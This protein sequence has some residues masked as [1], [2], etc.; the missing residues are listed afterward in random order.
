MRQC[1]VFLIP[2]FFYFH[3]NA[4]QDRGCFRIMFWN[5]ENFYDTRKD[6][7]TNDEEFLPTGTRFWTPKRYHMKLLHAFKVFTAIGGWEPPDIIGLCE[8]ENRKV[9]TDLIYDTP[10]CK[11]EYGIVH[12]DSPDKRGIDVGMLYRKDTFRPLLSQWIR[13][14]FPDQPY[15]TTRDIM[16]VKGIARGKS[17]D[18]D[19]LRKV[20]DSI[21]VKSI[22][23]T[24]D[25]P[26][27]KYYMDT[28]HVFINHWPSRS[29]GQAR[30]D[31]KRLAAA[32]ILRA[33][34]D[35]LL[36]HEPG[37]KI[38]ITGDFN[39][40]PSDYS[41]T[42]G[43]G[44]CSTSHSADSCRLMNLSA[45][46]QADGRRGTHK[47]DGNWAVLDQLIVSGQ[48]LKSK[49]GLFC[50]QEDARIFS[51]DFLLVE[52]ENGLGRRPFRTYDGYRYTGGFS[53][54]LPVYLDLWP[55]P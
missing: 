37:A 16:Y 40:E 43:L 34:I 28:L 13:V 30:T 52:D 44:T 14:R 32:R 47:F 11:F 29:A 6:S 21:S 33:C 25:I 15:E 46:L 39:D 23:G 42:H 5:T 27:I 45:A 51:A 17:T 55:A 2:V 26:E 22:Q 1:I 50:R 4:Q 38:I 31:N 35:S 10:L 24:A 36:E 3:A 9:L 49:T 48:L 53:D 20:R 7:L 54:H 8:I 41:L 19:S 12:K 18:K